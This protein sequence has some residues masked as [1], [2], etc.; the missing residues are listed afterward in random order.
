VLAHEL[1][2]RTEDRDAVRQEL[3]NVFLVAHDGAAIALTSIVFD[4]ARHPA[5][6]AR[7]REEVL[8]LGDAPVIFEG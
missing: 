6:W 2:K 4:L 8:R 3:L 5:V 7:L 1:A